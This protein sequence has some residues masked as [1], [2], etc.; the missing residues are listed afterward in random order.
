MANDIGSQTGTKGT[1]MALNGQAGTGCQKP[2]MK[3]NDSPGGT[4]PN[5][6]EC[7]PVPMPK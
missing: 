5:K 2:S 6:P 3:G 4:K 1:S 7:G